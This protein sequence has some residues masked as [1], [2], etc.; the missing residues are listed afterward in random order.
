MKNESRQNCAG[1]YAV[2]SLL[3]CGL[4]GNTATADVFN[5]YVF[6]EITSL[7]GYVLIAMGGSRGVISAFRYLLIG[8]IGAS[9]LSFGRGF[10]IRRNRDTEYAG[11]GGACRSGF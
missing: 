1:Y 10:Y 9:F 8:T 2:L 11:Y 3:V 7:S 5:L 4:L 6:L